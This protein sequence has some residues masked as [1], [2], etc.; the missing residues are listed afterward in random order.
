[1]ANNLQEHL[2]NLSIKFKNNEL[3]VEELQ[4]Y[5][6]LLELMN[7]VFRVYELQNKAKSP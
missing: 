7:S 6:D 2:S 5:R 4:E 1:M 3:S